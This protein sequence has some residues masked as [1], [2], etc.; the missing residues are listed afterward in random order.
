MKKTTL[1]L[2]LLLVPCSTFAQEPAP[3]GTSNQ[4]V[5]W[6]D[7]F[8]GSHNDLPLFLQVGYVNKDWRTDFGDKVIHENFWGQLDKK[9]HG[10]QIG[11]NYQPCAPSGFGF[12]MGLFYEFYYSVSSAVHD[13]GYD[14]FREHCLYVPLHALY[15]IPFTRNHSLILFGGIGV[16]WSMF[17]TFNNE[18]YDR[19]DDSWTSIPEK[20]QQYGNNE[21][22]RRLNM[23]WEVGANLRLSQFLLGFTYSRGL[24]N[25]RF[26]D[27]EFTQQNKLAFSLGIF[28]DD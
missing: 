3:V 18:Y 24:T 15:R 5:S 1:Y 6:F 12:R 21:W 4:S 23:Q 11:L 13:A 9:I 25:H 8:T 27:R 26:Y 2:L 22:P 28:L 7:L 17:G 20:F 14:D 10:L 16:N 19:W